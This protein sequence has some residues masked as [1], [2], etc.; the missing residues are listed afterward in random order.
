[1]RIDMKAGES[2]MPASAMEAMAQIALRGDV[3]ASTRRTVQIAG[4]L[5]LL[6]AEPHPSGA[7]LLRR[8]PA[9]QL[10]VA[11]CTLA[12]ESGSKMHVLELRS[13]ESGP[14]VESPQ[15]ARP[16]P[17]RTANQRRTALAEG[18]LCFAGDKCDKGL[19]C[20][21][22]LCVPQANAPLSK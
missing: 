6:V 22:N 18:E 2:L 11:Y 20:E 16:N 1:M 9:K 19:V 4:W 10:H 8:A 13:L 21:S 17:A 14:T 3:N 7:V 12:E 5:K 15:A